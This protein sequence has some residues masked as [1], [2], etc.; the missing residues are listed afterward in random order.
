MNRNALGFLSA[1][2]LMGAAPI[3]ARRV[4]LAGARSRSLGFSNSAENLRTRGPI[5]PIHVGLPS[6]MVGGIRGQGETPPP[7]E[8]IAALI[9]TGAS[10]TAINNGVAQRLGLIQT[11]SVTVGGVTGTS[12]QPIYTAFVGF[13]DMGMEFDPV[14][15][16]GT[17]SQFPGFDVLIGRNILCQMILSYNG[18]K[19]IFSL[20]S[21]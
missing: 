14:Q 2:P 8:E 1:T 3:G 9:D 16:A 6:V 5:L 10:I 17:P 20:Q 7:P 18:S 15:L 21:A 13:P 12:Q 4:S 11:G 19:G